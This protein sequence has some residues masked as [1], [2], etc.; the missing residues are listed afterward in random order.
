MTG[1]KKELGFWKFQGDRKIGQKNA[2]LAK[3]KL[4]EE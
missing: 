3:V 1:T 2:E 4:M